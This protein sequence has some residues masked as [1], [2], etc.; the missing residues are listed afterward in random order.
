VSRDPEQ[1]EEF[2]RT[3]VLEPETQ[4]DYLEAVGG[5][6]RLMEVRL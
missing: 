6:A 4:A 5:S 1:T 2:I 3:Y